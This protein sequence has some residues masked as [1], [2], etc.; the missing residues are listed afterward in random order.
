VRQRLDHDER[1]AQI[2]AC[3][4]RLF[5]QSSYGAVSMEAVAKDAGVT[6]G[7]LNHYFGTKRDLYLTVLRETFR[8]GEP[9]VPE[10]VVGATPADRVAES[11]ERW[12]DMVWAARD[13]WLSTLGAE[14]LGR[15]PE[16]EDIVERVRE[17]SVDKVIEVLGLRNDETPELRAVVRGYGGL[18]EA[19]T[20][21]WLLR[22]R[23]T[24]EQVQTLLTE[25]LLRLVEDVLPRLQPAG[26]QAA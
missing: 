21:E 16:V 11:V 10:Y 24:R 26:R 18:A 14:G 12:L 6:R 23:L 7:L 20:R 4:R 22:E 13:T 3:A 25:S 17:R 5:A 19:T 2:L 1:Q 9:P 8:G 15:D